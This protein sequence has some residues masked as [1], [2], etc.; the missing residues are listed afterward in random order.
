MKSIN[1]SGIVAALKLAV[2]AFCLI[3]I[4][5]GI[6]GSIHFIFN[7]GR[8]V[9][10]FSMLAGN[11]PYYPLDSG[12]ILNC[13]YGPLS[14]VYYFPCAFFRQNIS[15]AL[16]FGS[17]LSFA[18]FAIPAAIILYRWRKNIC[19]IQIIWLAALGVLQIIAY[20][21]FSY[22]AFN[23]HADAPAVFFSSLC[24]LL[25]DRNEDGITSARALFWSTAFGVLTI[26]TKQ[27][28]AAVVLLPIIVALAEKQTW[29]LRIALAGWVFLLNALFFLI[30]ALW[31]GQAALLDNFVKIPG[32]IP[33]IQASF[34]YGPE[35]GGNGHLKSVVIAA[36]IIVGKY[37]APYLLCLAAFILFNLKNG[38]TTEN[39]VS[40]CLPRLS[41]GFF[42]LALLNL[43]MAASVAL[44]IGA[45]ANS[46]T[47]F[48]WFFILGIFCLVVQS[49]TARAPAEIPSAN[50]AVY[51]IFTGLALAAFIGAVRHLP[52]T[53]K[54]ISGVFDNDE[55]AIVQICSQSPGKYYFPWHPLAGYF[56][57][58]RFYHYEYMAE[59]HAL[60]SVTTSR[61]HFNQFIPPHATIIGLPNAGG[62]NLLGQYM[63][64]IQPCGGPP[65][66]RTNSLAWFSFELKP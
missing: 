25:L 26:W 52:A 10:A 16:M 2:A 29:R 19:G 62:T 66:A 30:F 51:Y 39:S 9:P 43:P 6:A 32:A 24:V 11:P 58:G 60:A 17:L 3:P 27:T 35:A 12:P 4:L 41:G 64:N 57:E 1:T 54:N 46:D 42:L 63:Q 33:S 15:L 50:R 28:Y 48:A 59:V 49:Q 44:K 20:G 45:S 47:P 55:A 34:L 61:R 36:H 7:D 14:Y 23:I 37:L 5:G 53:F 38:R 13:V 31:C 18:A 22:S 8:L 21:S 40:F 65:T 56:G